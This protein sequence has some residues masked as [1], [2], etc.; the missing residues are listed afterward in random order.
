MSVTVVLAS[1]VSSRESGHA[2]VGVS[3]TTLPSAESVGVAPTAAAPF[4]SLTPVVF[5]R[6]S[7][8]VTWTG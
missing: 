5:A 7:L 4:R 8:N 6:G 1:M 3:V 2:E